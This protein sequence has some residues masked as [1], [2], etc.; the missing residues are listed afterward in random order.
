MKPTLIIHPNVIVH[1]DRLKISIG[2]YF[3]DTINKFWFKLKIKKKYK[4]QCMLFSSFDR[5]P[6][7]KKFGAYAAKYIK[8]D[9]KQ[10]CIKDISLIMES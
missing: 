1:K 6:K 2:E 4:N 5:R 10:K 9:F 3:G 7:F 8:Y